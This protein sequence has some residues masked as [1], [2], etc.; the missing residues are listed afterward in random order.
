LITVAKTTVLTS[1]QLANIGISIVTGLLNATIYIPIVTDIFEY[2]TGE[3]STVG[4]IICYIFAIPLTILWKIM[5][6][7]NFPNQWPTTETRSAKSGKEQVGTPTTLT[8]PQKLYIAS[9]CVKLVSMPIVIINDIISMVEEFVPASML[10]KG[11]INVFKGINILLSAAQVAFSFSYSPFPD[12]VDPNLDIGYTVICGYPGL[13]VILDGINAY[14][15]S[16]G[17]EYFNIGL[18][19]LYLAYSVAFTI[20]GATLGYGTTSQVLVYCDNIMSPIEPLTKFVLRQTKNPYAYIAIP[21]VSAA[22]SVIIFALKIASINAL[23]PS[24]STLLIEGAKSKSKKEKKE[25][26]PKEKKE[27]KVK[28]EKEKKDKKKV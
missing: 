25:K 10:N 1:L 27:K 12:D 14:L 28:V 11:K 24:A 17:L 19:G 21:I 26:A 18:N 23:P 4:N 5:Y 8:I 13:I 7:E 9:A 6:N 15:G 16:K 22:F 2:L 20:W 3:S